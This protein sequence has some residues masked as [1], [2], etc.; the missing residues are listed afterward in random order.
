MPR[1]QR[2]QLLRDW[3]NSSRTGASDIV[4]KVA[5]DE[6]EELHLQIK[7]LNMELERAK[8]AGF[9]G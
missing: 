1:A 9:R 2:M 8:A 4:A 6:I 3:A 5:L 7:S